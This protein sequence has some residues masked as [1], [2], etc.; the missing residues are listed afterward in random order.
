MKDFVAPET[1]NITNCGTINITKTDDAATPNRL[2]GATFSLYNDNSTVGGTRTSADTLTNPLLSCTTAGTGASAGTCSI[3]NVP[4]GNYW[5][6]ETTTPA[7]Y[8]TA[9]DQTASLSSGTTSVS[10]TFV[11][12]KILLQPTISTAQSFVPNDSATVSVADSTQGALAGN[13]VFQLYSDSQCSGTK[14]Y[15]SGDVAIASGSG[16][17]TSRT[18][19]SSNTTAYSASSTFYWKVTYTSTNSGHKNV[20][21]DCIEQSSITIDNDN[22]T[23]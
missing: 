18:V 6:V 7:G 14:L 12:P 5:V 2:N 11:D 17:G 4:F 1:V 22:T 20:T 10:L 3:T 21:S 13:V 8:T 15:D 9:P 23:P 16:S 19:S